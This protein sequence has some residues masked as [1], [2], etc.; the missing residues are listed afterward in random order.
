MDE[1]KWGRI[2]SGGNP[3]ERIDL[4]LQA[5]EENSAEAVPFLLKVLHDTD[6]IYELIPFSHEKT[7]ISEVA[8]RALGDLKAAEAV[9]LFE[10]MRKSL[11]LYSEKWVH[12]TAQ[13]I[14]IG[15]VSFEDMKTMLWDNGGIARKRDFLNISQAVSHIRKEAIDFL[16][17]Q[18]S[19]KELTSLHRSISDCLQIAGIVTKEKG[20]F[21]KK[22][23]IVKVLREN[24]EWEPPEG[25]NDFGCIY[26]GT[27]RKRVR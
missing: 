1:K 12:I 20:F 17:T 10:E 21:F 7:E 22:F 26:D 11:P 5:I 14:K 6:G 2:V 15:T 8:I 9:P 27:C 23:V 25:S 18:L 19:N 13:L 24:G 3:K 16:L 4:I